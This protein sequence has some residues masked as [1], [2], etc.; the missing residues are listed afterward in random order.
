M[1][2]KLAALF[3]IP[4]ILALLSLSVPAAAEPRVTSVT[5]FYEV[6]GADKKTVWNEMRRKIPKGG[7]RHIGYTEYDITWSYDLDKGPGG[8]RL[9]DL[10]VL[11][12]IVI[13][14]PKWS[15]APAPDTEAGRDW[16]RFIKALTLHER[17][18]ADNAVRA[19]GEA[20]AA[21]LRAAGAADCR[22]LKSAI[23]AAGR[24]AVLEARRRDTRYDQETRHGLTQGAVL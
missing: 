16:D 15:D 10:T 22:R 23:D 20:E 19:A 6:R 12:D 9:T 11:V 4:S 3:I 24:K 2:A 17:G 13:H 7:G 14:L 1:P 8:C 5:R 18:H 21:M